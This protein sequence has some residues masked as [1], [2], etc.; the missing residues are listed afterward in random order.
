M[1]LLVRK[2]TWGR[3]GMNAHRRDGS[4][5][6]G[7]VRSRRT[8]AFRPR[9]EE[10]GR[11][12]ARRARQPRHLGGKR[13]RH[14]AELGQVRPGRAERSG[15]AARGAPGAYTSQNRQSQARW[16]RRRASHGGQRLVVPARPH[17]LPCAPHLARKQPASARSDGGPTGEAPAAHAPCLA[18]PAARAAHATGAGPSSGAAR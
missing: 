17:P 2:T 9:G 4:G 5:L 13:G 11:S 18:S 1:H 7:E 15:S 12:H 14:G 16:C 6:P 8:R 10:P 3:G